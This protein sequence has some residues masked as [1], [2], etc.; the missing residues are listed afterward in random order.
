MAAPGGTRTSWIPSFTKYGSQS[1]IRLI[2]LRDKGSEASLR[3]FDRKSPC[4]ISEAKLYLTKKTMNRLYSFFTLVLGIALLSGCVAKKNLVNF[5]NQGRELPN[6][7][8]MKPVEITLEAGDVVNIEISGSDELTLAPFNASQINNGLNTLEA[9]QLTGYL[10]DKDGFITFPIVGEV[11]IKDLTVSEAKVKL[12]RELSDYLKDPVVNVRLLNFRVTVSGEVRSPGQFTVLNERISVPDAL[13]LAGGL[14]DYSNRNAVLLVRE[15]NGV[16]NQVRLD[17]QD[18]N[19]FDSPY[20]YLKQNDMLYIEPRR[21]K[22]GAVPDQTNK[23]LPVLGAITGVA[24][25]LVT[26]IN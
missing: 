8:P 23:I 10:I 17:L 14:T 11:N 25:L 6:Q 1:L 7:Q 15:E 26:I 22:T 4:D 12:Q 16:R 3:F 9:I 24:A 13:A 2:I 20:Y 21:Y 18:D 19:F 5:E